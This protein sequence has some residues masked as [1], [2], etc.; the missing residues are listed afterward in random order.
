MFNA[1]K[2]SDGENRAN[3]GDNRALIKSCAERN[4]D[5]SRAPH[6]RRGGKTGN[7]ES[8]LNKY[9]TYAEETYAGNNLCSNT[10]GITAAAETLYR[11]EANHSCKRCSKANENMCTHTCGSALLSSL[12]AERSAEQHSKYKS[13]YNSPNVKV[14][15]KSKYFSDKIHTDSSLSID[16]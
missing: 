14:T 7:L 16:K 4:T 8:A 9:S 12:K 15:K 10:K 6:T 1:P 2:S 3:E 13:D 11:V 5:C